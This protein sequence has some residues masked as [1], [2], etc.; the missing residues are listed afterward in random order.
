NLKAAAIVGYVGD[1]FGNWVEPTPDGYIIAGSTTVNCTVSSTGVTHSDIYAV[2]LDHNLNLVWDK[3][4]GNN[5]IQKNDV[6]YCVKVDNAGAYVLT[7]ETQSHASPGG[8]A[9]L[10]KF[11]PAGGIIFYRT[12]SGPA[13]DQGRSLI[14]HKTA[15]GVEYVVAGITNSYNSSGTPDGFLFKTD[16]NGGLIWARVYGKTKPDFTYEVDFSSASQNGY[17]LAGH[18]FSFGAGNSDAYLIK[19]DINGV[20]GGCE[21]RVFPILQ[22]YA[23]C[24]YSATRVVRVDSERPVSTSSFPITYIHSK[25]SVLMS[26]SARAEESEEAFVTQAVTL[27]PNPAQSHLHISIVADLKGSALSI[28]D[29]D[30][31][32]VLDL[33]LQEEFQDISLESLRPGLYMVLITQPDGTVLKEKLIVQ[34]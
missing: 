12:Y 25:C 13:N 29:L 28:K 14:V 22:Y 23:P 16:Q 1:Q 32:G 17:V 26:A 2:K 6:A 21:K 4:V 24:V 9:F 27:S 10:L 20:S 5:N 19:T 33:T 30:G 11:N 34:D 31:K 8:N 7:G 15:T 18:E 3:I